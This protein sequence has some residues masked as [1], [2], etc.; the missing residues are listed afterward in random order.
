MKL[1]NIEL[2][3][4]GLLS[5]YM[6]FATHPAPQV[7]SDVVGHP[8][9]LL[10]GLG[11]VVFLGMKVSLLV[12]LFAAMALLLSLRSG[13]ENFEPKKEE[14]KPE[15]KVPVA[16]GVPKPD[17][18]GALGRLLQTAGK[19]VTKPPPTTSVTKPA[20]ITQHKEYTPVE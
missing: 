16:Q 17:L 7:V 12:G 10:V 18:T 13:F 19:S 11:L 4:L 9:G 1:S 15:H 5:L 2:V 8:V 6:A 14:K 3:S 20:N